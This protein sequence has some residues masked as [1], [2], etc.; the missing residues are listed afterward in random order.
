MF[1]K[2]I[3]VNDANWKENGDFWS[4]ILCCWNSMEI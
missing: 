3:Q 1:L 4:E 2:K